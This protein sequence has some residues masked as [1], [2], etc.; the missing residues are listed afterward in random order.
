[1][2]AAPHAHD[3]N[4]LLVSQTIIEAVHSEDV[5]S[6]WFLLRFLPMEASMVTS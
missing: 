3:S 2:V 1:M 6:A 4:S 5:A